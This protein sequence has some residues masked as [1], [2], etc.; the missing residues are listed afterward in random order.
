MGDVAEAKRRI[1]AMGEDGDLDLSYLKLRVLPELPVGLKVLRC[2]STNFPAGLKTLYC[3][4]NYLSV[5]PVLPD[6]LKE[7]FCASNQLT[8]LPELPA[9]LK[10]LNCSQ[11]ELTVLPE[12]PAGLIT[13]NCTNNLFRE[14]FLTLYQNY[15]ADNNINKL[16]TSIHS[17]YANLRNL[18]SR[19]RNVS[20]LRVALGKEENF[21]NPFKRSGREDLIGSFLT[22]KSSFLPLR[23]QSSALKGNYN[24]TSAGLPLLSEE[25]ELNL[26][27]RA[28]NAAGAGAPRKGGR[29]TTRKRSRKGSRRHR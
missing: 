22:G 13:L 20:S 29:R 25:E 27:A 12:L 9:G 7:L 4:T 10:I 5:L 16:R 1:A 14:P 18:E 15:R 17:Y 6:G 19:G 23:N 21:N 24:R 11:N 3:S 2:D 28:R 26:A 8:V